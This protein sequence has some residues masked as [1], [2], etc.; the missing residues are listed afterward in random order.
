MTLSKD[1]AAD[2]AVVTSSAETAEG[3]AARAAQGDAG[4]TT[5]LLR[6]L[7]PKMARVVRGVLG[8]ASCDVDD[9][10]QQSLVGVVQAL[11]AFRGECSPEGYACRIAFRTALAVRKAGHRNRNRMDDTFVLESAAAPEHAHSA[12]TDMMRRLLSEIPE[13][14]A[15]A[16]SLR[17][18]LG[19]SIDEIAAS[20]GVPGN[21]VRSRLRLAKE[22][23]RKRIEAEPQLRQHFEIPS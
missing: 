3:L 11:A 7:A 2:L 10:M 9:A 17:V 18:I 5:Q 15:E 21:T 20:A 6:L 19:W 22:A 12:S 16:L 14:Q 13:E 4:A 23:L 1:V 8:P